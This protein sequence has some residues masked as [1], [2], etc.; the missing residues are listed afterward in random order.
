MHDFDVQRCELNRQHFTA[1][2]GSKIDE[3][4]FIG[5]QPRPS[6]PAKVHYLNR[7][8]FF[9]ERNRHSVEF[10]HQTYNYNCLAAFG[11]SERLT[12]PEHDEP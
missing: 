12:R 10:K 8:E 11:A 4:S 3:S 2:R 1:V 7:S 9:E 6:N 5:L